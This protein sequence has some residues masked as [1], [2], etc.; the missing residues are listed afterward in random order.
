MRP[1]AR[2]ALAGALVTTLVLLPTT[3][4]AQRVLSMAT[5]APSGSL[6]MRVLDAMN[7]E[8]RRRTGGQLSF[9]WYVG[10]VQGDESEVVRKIRSGRLDGGALT[11]TGLAQVYRP[12]LAFQLPAVFRTPEGFMRAFTTLRPELEA[13]FERAGFSILNLSPATGPRMFSTREIRTPED[14]RAARPWRWTDDPILPALYAETGATGVPLSLPEVLGGLQTRRIDT[15]FAPPSAAIALQW[16]QHVRYMSERPSSGSLAG[17]VISRTAAQSLTP[18]QRTTITEVIAQA[19]TIYRPAF[20]RADGDAVRALTTRGVQTVALTEPQRE[21]W[22]D[23]FARV[24]SRVS[25]TLPDPGFLARV[26]AA[27]R[28]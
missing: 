19:T 13:G 10:G 20:L 22:S 1:T 28:E 23:V 16:S 12:V 9:R 8:L 5:L 24:R 21:R 25:A 27:G 2:R 11:A 17:L 4:L 15:V 14:L 18:A 7:R 3:A 6:P 26:Q